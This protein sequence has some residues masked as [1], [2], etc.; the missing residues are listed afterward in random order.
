V[1]STNSRDEEKESEAVKII[2]GKGKMEKVRPK[3]DHNI[4]IAGLLITDADTVLNKLEREKEGLLKGLYVFPKRLGSGTVYICNG[5]E[6]PNAEAV[7]LLLYLLHIAEK[8]NWPRRIKI[9]S[10]NTL[11][12]EIFGI[13]QSGKHWNEKIERGLVIWANHKFYF[14]NCFFWQGEIIDTVMLGIIQSFKIEK[15]GKGKPATLT[16]TFDEDF[17]EICRETDWYRRPPWLE[18]KKLR[19]ET[20]KSLYLLALE[21][22]PDEKTKE[23]KIYI[24]HDLKSWYR[25]TLNSLASPKHLRPAII[26]RRLKG[27]I[28]EINE[29]TN[30]RMEL[31]QTEEGN[32]CIAVEEVAPVGSE[33]LDIPFDKLSDE[34]KAILVAYIEAVAE[35]KKIKNV[36]GFLRS[37]TTRQVKLWLNR[38]KKYFNSEVQK[39]KESELVEKPKLL[40]VLRN[41]GSKK[42]PDKEHLYRLYFGEDKILKAY[43]NNKKV[44]FVCLDKFLA[45]L[46][47]KFSSELKEVF[48]KEVIFVGQE[49]NLV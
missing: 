25:N 21:F 36:W 37:M 18:I 44:V 23:W 31:Q 15:H 38:A 24:E 22:K 28:E 30:L 43:E 20:A 14:K 6:F 26:L 45:G 1:V 7:D 16:I 3:I 48:G 35:E 17:I 8:H 19:K 33:I 2:V 40:K 32:Y 4:N 42:Y 11:A 47:S 41:W 12:K 27:A 39:A 13:K 10:L 49:E 34:D 5:A 29:K 46:L 9:S